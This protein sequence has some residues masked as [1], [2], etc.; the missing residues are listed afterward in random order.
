M[1]SNDEL[2][3]KHHPDIAVF[4][5]RVVPVPVPSRTCPKFHKKY[6]DWGWLKTKKPFKKTKYI[7]VIKLEEPLYIKIDGINGEGVILKENTSEQSIMDEQD[8]SGI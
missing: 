3:L 8:S 2:W 6:I 5:D 7:R 1:H 4:P